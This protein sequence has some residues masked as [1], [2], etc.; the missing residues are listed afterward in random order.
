MLFRREKP[1]EDALGPNSY[2]IWQ[3][4]QVA[5]ETAEIEKIEQ[6]TSSKG[7]LR[8]INPMTYVGGFWSSLLDDNR[9]E[10]IK[11]IISMFGILATASAAVGL[12]WTVWDAT[13]D[14]KLTQERLITDRFSKA[15]TLLSNEDNAVRIAAIYSLERI[16]KDSPRDHWTIMELLSAYVLERSP[17]DEEDKVS[18]N[19]KDKASKQN[20]ISKQSPSTEVTKKSSKSPKPIANDVQAALTVIGRR[21]SGQD[22]GKQ[23]DL[24]SHDLS[25]ADLSYADL[26]V[27][28]LR[29]ANLIDANLSGAN[30]RG[31]NLIDAN[32][33]GANLIDAN[34]SDAYLSIANFIGANL[35]GANLSYSNLRKANLRHAHLSGANFRKANLS[36]ADISK[37]HLGH[38]HLNDADLSGAYFSGAYLYKANLSS[39]FLIGADLSR[40]NLSD[41]ILR[42]ANLLS[43]NLSD[44]SLSS[45][46]LNNAI[47][48]NTDLRETHLIQ[49][50]LESKEPPLI[51]N[52][53]LHNKIKIERNRDCDKVAAALHKRLPKIFP[54]LD[55]A[56]IFVKEEQLK[57]WN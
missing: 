34:L 20:P 8:W 1:S 51:C 26:S 42:G 50:Q 25:G 57:I 17:L 35:G 36:L 32:L 37:A 45:A 16:A 44:A 33:R 5:I 40:A 12:I 53:P 13:E 3:E 14:R 6:K 21:E 15:A 18:K 24:R 52:S 22:Q 23:L 30:L 11:V 48:L 54:S 47:L 56:E 9:R 10:A 46:D 27:A 2:E 4:K 43:A 49:S 19:E 55:D 28:I 7:Y 29:G 39:A 38:A 31:A 41:V